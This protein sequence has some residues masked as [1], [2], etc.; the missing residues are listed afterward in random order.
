MRVKAVLDRIEAGRAVLL[1]GEN[2][3]AV[4]W[5][6]RLLPPEAKEGDILVFAIDVDEQAT[7]QSRQE[8]E[9]LLR[10]ILDQQTREE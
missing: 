8:A 6:R 4:S 2:E 9:K 10:Q 5:P 1:A 3:T 7:R